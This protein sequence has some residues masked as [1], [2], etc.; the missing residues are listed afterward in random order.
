MPPNLSDAKRFREVAREIVREEDGTERERPK[1]AEFRRENPKKRFESIKVISS[2]PS[3]LQ[4]DVQSWLD[5]QEEVVIHRREHLIDDS[6]DTA[7]IHA[8]FYYT[9]G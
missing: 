6:G 5:E 7:E 2:A 9:E 1:Q 4:A 8:I 3:N